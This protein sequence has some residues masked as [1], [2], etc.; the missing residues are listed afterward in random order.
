MNEN[1][2]ASGTEQHTERP[3]QPEIKWQCERVWTY[4]VLRNQSEWKC[5]FHIQ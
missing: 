1:V 4:S 5:H 3:Y 2:H